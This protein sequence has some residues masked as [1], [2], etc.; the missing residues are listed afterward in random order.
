MEENKKIKRLAITAGIFVFAIILVSAIFIVA[1]ARFSATLDLVVAPA[2]AEVMIDGKK[3]ENGK[4]EFE[5]GEKT[6][7]ITKEGFE[8]QEMTVNLIANETT[9]LYTYLLPADGSYAWYLEHEDDMMLLNTIGDAEA[10]KAGKAYLEKNPIVAVLPIVYAN[11]DSDW[12]Y[13]EYRIDGG[14]FDGCKTEFCLK[15]TDTTG[16][17]YEAALEVIRGKGFLPEDFEILYEYKPI[18]P[19]K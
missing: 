1:R 12:N 17:N 15:I 2:S 8:S 11:Y 5:P 3:Y 19:L 9:K 4:Y 14:S 16:G 7:V 10:A 18:E 13:T 6:V